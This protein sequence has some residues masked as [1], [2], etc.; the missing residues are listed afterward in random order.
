[1][2][3]GSVDRLEKSKEQESQTQPEMFFIP[4][5][6]VAFERS[7]RLSPSEQLDTPNLVSTAK[8]K[9]DDQNWYCNEACDCV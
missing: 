6:R 2:Q 9:D 3:Q 1:M 4:L 7:E 5:F 8:R